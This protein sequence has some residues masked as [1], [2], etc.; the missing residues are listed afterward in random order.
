VIEGARRAEVH[1]LPKAG[2]AVETL[3]G[4]AIANAGLRVARRCKLVGVKA[5]TA[6]WALVGR[7]R[8]ALLKEAR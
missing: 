8:G 4:G 3:E 5:T 1:A 7:E 2:E 6:L